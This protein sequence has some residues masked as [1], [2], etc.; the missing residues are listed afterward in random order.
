MHDARPWISGIPRTIEVGVDYIIPADLSLNA[1]P[2][3]RSSANQSIRITSLGWP[4]FEIIPAT[5]LVAQAI[6]MDKFMMSDLTRDELKAIFVDLTEDDIR[7]HMYLY[8]GKDFDAASGD[9][10]PNVSSNDLSYIE[11]SR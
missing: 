9:R 4:F 10:P 1:L 6:T 11:Q 5:P 2:S 8:S 7:S 3:F